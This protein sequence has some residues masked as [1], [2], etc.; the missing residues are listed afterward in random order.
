MFVALKDICFAGK[1]YLAGEEI[2]EG[3][4]IPSRVTALLRSHWIAEQ[5]KGTESYLADAEPSDPKADKISVLIRKTEHGL[6]LKPEEVPQIFAIMQMNVEEAAEAIA[7]L[8]S[9][10]VLEVLKE[11][12]SRKGVKTAAEARMKE[13]ETALPAEMLEDETEPE[14]AGKN[15]IQLLS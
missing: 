8:E 6:F 13:I 4:V 9:G 7:M 2:P 3:A 12:E 15:D 5:K 1:K 11:V 10:N 14:G